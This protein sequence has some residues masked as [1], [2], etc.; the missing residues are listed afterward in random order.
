MTAFQFSTDLTIAAWIRPDRVVNEMIIA[1]A[2]AITP[3]WPQ[4]GLFV[5][6]GPPASQLRY[7]VDS[8]GSSRGYWYAL[9]Q[10][11]E[12]TWYHVA[13]TQSGPNSLPDLYVDGV[14]YPVVVDMLWGAPYRTTAPLSLGRQGATDGA[15]FRGALDEIQIYDRALAP[16]EIA[17]IF[18]A[19]STG[20]CPV[21]IEQRSWGSVKRLYD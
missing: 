19:G 18:N 1:T 12:G 16:E 21:S 5:S 15:Y 4:S 6:A 3:P 13:V 7:F 10:F 17:A 9:Y 11:V 2:V 20:N 8:D 14:P